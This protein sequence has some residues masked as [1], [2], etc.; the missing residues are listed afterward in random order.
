MANTITKTINILL[1]EDNPVD[2]RLIQELLRDASL[3]R[4]HIVTMATLS[5]ALNFL[6]ENDVD[7]VLLDL[8]LPDSQG[9]AT[10]KAVY[11]RA[12]TIPIIM[13]TVLDEEE[14]KEAAFRQGAQDYLTKEMLSKD[15][16]TTVLLVRAISYAIE[17]KRAEERVEEH[18]QTIEILNQIATKG[19]RA[20]DV[21]SFIEVATKLTIELIHFDIGGIYLIGTDT[22]YATLQYVER[23]PEATLELIEKIPYHDPP[24]NSILIDGEPLFAEDYGVFVAQHPPWGV[25][26]LASVPL[27]SQEV[28]IGVLNVGSATP[29]SF[30]QE[31]KDLLFAMGSEVGAIITKLQTDEALRESLKERE[32]LLKEIHHRVKNNMQIVSSLLS[33]QAAQ[34]TE[35]ET[36]DML[37]ECQRRITSMALIHEKLYRSDSF[38]DIN[39][40]DYVESLTDELL[41][42]NR[43]DPNTVRITKDI[44]NVQFDVDTAIPCALI[45]NELV[46]NCLKHAHLD[47]RTGEIAIALHR[48]NGTYELTVADNGV[49]FPADLDFQTTDSLGMQLVTALVNQLDGTITLDRAKGTTFSITFESA[50]V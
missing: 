27:Y 24:F 17:R 13:F 1:V 19:N 47:A 28:I 50:G 25:A 45:V 35:P 8:G 15:E 26:S 44:E 34:A 31:E 20:T 5:D 32:T 21:Q 11:E 30:S 3:K 29:H 48:I 33:M 36:V 9:L 6:S 16:I 23:L 49:G 42:M 18:A 39:F 37:N 43:V 38:T 46:S 41:R 7:V 40:A 10:F 22:H 2:S 14:V 12:P 4:F